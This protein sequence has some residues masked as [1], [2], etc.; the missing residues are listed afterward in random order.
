MQAALL[1]GKQAAAC[2]IYYG[3]PEEN[4]DRLK[5]LNCD[6]LDIFATKDKWINAEVTA[7]FENNMKAAGKKVIVRKYEADHAFDQHRFAGPGRR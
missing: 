4:V 6:V 7:K 3:M 2:V 5:T 1:A